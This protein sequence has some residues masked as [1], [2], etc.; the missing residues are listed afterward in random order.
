MLTHTKPADIDKYVES[1]GHGDLK[2]KGRSG[3]ELGLSLR[4]SDVAPRH[5]AAA[6]S[7]K[8]NSARTSTKFKKVRNRRNI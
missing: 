1:W 8:C 5:V 3:S 4:V 2:R 6:G 7:G